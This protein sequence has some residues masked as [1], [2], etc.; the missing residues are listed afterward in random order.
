MKRQPKPFSIEIKR[1]RRSPVPSQPS[2]Q[3]AEAAGRNDAVAIK[4]SSAR[5][6]VMKPAM[7]DELVIPTFLQTDSISFRSSP[8]S[9][10]KE[11][12]EVFA[13]KSTA[14]SAE[15]G[16]G[17]HVSDKRALPRIL[18]SLTS[19]YEVEQIHETTEQPVKSRGRS[20]VGRPKGAPSTTPKIKPTAAAA[21]GPASSTRAAARLKPAPKLESA[22]GLSSATAQ[23]RATPTKEK[24][25]PD[26]RFARG[27][28]NARSPASA[29]EPP[30]REG[31]FH[32]AKR[33]NVRR[34]REDA[35]SLPRGERWKRRLHPSVW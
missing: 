28:S 14:R 27:A 26:A 18:P 8:K 6:R 25:Q 5:K 11:L 21:R 1:S 12:E 20:A 13:V 30:Q 15:L 3:G 2:A 10:A 22:T 24:A 29:T 17:E 16:A 9:I 34:G 7:D 32:Q 23:K 31:A 4:A 35:A 19:G 33:R